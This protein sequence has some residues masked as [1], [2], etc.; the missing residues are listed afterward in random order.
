LES[1]YR[2]VE[3]FIVI[4]ALF[5]RPF[6]VYGRFIDCI[7]AAFMTKLLCNGEDIT[8]ELLSGTTECIR[9]QYLAELRIDCDRG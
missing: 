4:T 2:F 6:L 7:S 3:R 5:L 9:I 1:L 8:P